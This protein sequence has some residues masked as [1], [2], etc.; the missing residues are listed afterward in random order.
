MI[1]TSQSRSNHLKRLRLFANSNNLTCLYRVRR[2][3]NNLSI[4]SNMPVANKLTCSGTCGSNTQTVH[5]IVQTALEELEQNLTSHTTA[6]SSLLEEIVELALK[7]TIGV[8]CL[9]LLCQLNTVLRLFAT[10]VVTMLS[11]RE[12][13]LSQYLICTENGLTETTC[14]SRLW[15][16]ISCHNL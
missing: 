14:Y 15:T 2:N 9:L 7:N 5:H 16:N 3:T 4:Y 12:I 11:W 8:L 10:A 6:L 1:E 13:T